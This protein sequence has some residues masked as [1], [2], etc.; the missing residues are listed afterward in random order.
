MWRN[1]A[2]VLGAIACALLVSMPALAAQEADVSGEWVLTMTTPM[3]GGRTITGALTLEVED[4][5]ITGTF[6]REG[7]EQ[8]S[9]ITG[10]VEGSEISFTMT[11]MG[12]RR[13]RGPGGGRGGG[14][15]LTFTGTVEGEVMSGT[16]E[17]PR[18]TGEWTAE[19]PE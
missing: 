16:V 9:E 4:G 10:S 15:Q 3:G 7:A 11:G 13:G 5:E 6:L 17:L 1:T 12:A 19:R 8:P 18:A 2:V 14:F